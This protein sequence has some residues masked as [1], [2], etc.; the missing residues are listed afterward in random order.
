MID[1]NKICR[2][3]E[4]L[5]CKEHNK[6][7]KLEVNGDTIK[8]ISCCEKFQNELNVEIKKQMKIEAQ[9]YAK[10]TIDK[11]TKIFKK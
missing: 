8:T 7:P 3:V 4:T 5:S 11:L 1:L 6:K 10:D 2:N 9:K